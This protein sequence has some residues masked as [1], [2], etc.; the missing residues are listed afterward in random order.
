[1]GKYP[2]PTVRQYYILKNA[3]DPELT[4]RTAAEIM[5]RMPETIDELKRFIVEYL[6]EIEAIINNNQQMQIPY[7]P[8]EE[9]A[10]PHFMCNTEKLKLVIDYTGL[11]INEVWELNYFEYRGYLHDAFVWDRSGS[12]AGREYLKNAYDY[13]QTDPDRTGLRKVLNSGK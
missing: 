6:S 13:Q 2:M 4:V 10:E 12:K 8:V 3:S 5:G 9:K 7:Y 11:N 1:M